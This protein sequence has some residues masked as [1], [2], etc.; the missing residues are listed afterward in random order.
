MLVQVSETA[1]SAWIGRERRQVQMIDGSAIQRMAALLDLPDPGDEVP[2]LWHLT[3][4][5]DVAP[6]QALGRDGHPAVGGFMPP[7]P[8]PRRMFAGSKLVFDRRLKTG[9][10]AEMVERIVSI[11]EKVGKTGPLI[12]VGVERTFSQD[13]ERCLS[14]TNTIV[15]REDE[16]G[17]VKPAAA[18]PAPAPLAAPRPADWRVTIR[19]DP[20]WLFRYSAVTFNGHRI[21][22]D[23]TYA[24]GVE[25]Y[26]GLVVHGPLIATALLEAARKANPDRRI[27]GFSFRAVSPLFDIDPFHVCGAKSDG[28]AKLWAEGPGGREAM[29]ADISFA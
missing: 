1:L 7:V 8:L 20:V 26:P 22:Y 28:G 6:Q 17:G 16:A 13:G 11:D 24:T 12:F 18:A 27:T 14:E 25:G 10:Q 9:R 19:P 29:T 3:H 23:R 4:F 21:H 15:Y 5:M 2:E